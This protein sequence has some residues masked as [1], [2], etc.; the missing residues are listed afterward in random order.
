M[1][2]QKSTNTSPRKK[3]SG[4][5]ASSHPQPLRTSLTSA[6]L[7]A[8]FLRLIRHP[9]IKATL[10]LTQ[11]TFYERIFTVWVTLWLFLLQRIKAD[12]SLDGLV[13]DVHNGVADRIGRKA[14]R[15]PL[16]QRLRSNATTS[17]CDARKRL[18]LSVFITAL[19]A[20]AKEIWAQAQGMAWH[21]L[22]LILLDGST[23]RVRPYGNVPQRYPAHA[24]GKS[25]YWCLMRVVV[26]FCLHSGAVVG[27]AFASKY[28]GEQALACCLLMQALPSALYLGDRNFGVFR[29]VQAIIHGKGHVLVRLT[30]VRARK[31]LGKKRLVP[32]DYQVAWV[33]SRND[34]LQEGCS[35][36]PIEGRL[37]VVLLGG[38][39]W[40][41]RRLCL[42]TTLLDN[43]LYPLS[44][45]VQL[46]GQRWHVEINLRYLKTQMS[47]R[48]LR[49]K[50][51]DMDEK[52]WLA[53]LL[54]YNLIRSV[55]V[56][57]AA[58]NNLSVQELSF[59]CARRRV[60]EFVRQLGMCHP[61]LSARWEKLLAALAACRLPKR[62]QPRI[63]EPRLQRLECKKFGILRGSRDVARRRLNRKFIQKP[64]LKS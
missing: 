11:V 8:A 6:Q 31:V 60:L 52:E 22:R 56:A 55:M 10:H 42:F 13:C 58:Q 4:A 47:L 21:G 59:S 39:G 46:Y 57:A 18:P 41:C 53:G 23:V 44:E 19:A 54:A 15:L 63:N 12:S 64:A 51:A 35:A 36:E 27:T 49:C 45:L 1:P 26:G 48:E 17:L 38:R 28:I 34:T 30:D 24:S 16:S 37:I 5:P 20:Q 33:H 40:R 3:I 50:S 29:I 62:K 61:H 14:A 43:Q 2:I 32:G 25:G 9:E 7:L